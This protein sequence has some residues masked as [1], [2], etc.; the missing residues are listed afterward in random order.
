MKNFQQRLRII[1]D[2]QIQFNN[3]RYNQFKIDRK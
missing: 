1:A 3:I 2:E